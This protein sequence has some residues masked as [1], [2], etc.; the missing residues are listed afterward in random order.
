MDPLGDMVKQA[1]V[2]GQ[3]PCA[4]AFVI[5]QQQSIA[6]LQVGT[7]ADELDIRLSKCQLGLFG[8]GAKSE[9]KHRR[10]EAMQDVPV[11]M[12]SAIREAAGSSG[13]ITCSTAWKLAEDL[14]VARQV[15]SNAAEG[16]GIRIK[17]CQLGAF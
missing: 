13:S 1:L 8:Y 12:A 16:L 4:A 10:V 11:E 17:Q 7:K 5:A 15:V 9:G 2:E 3:L 14:S 6:P